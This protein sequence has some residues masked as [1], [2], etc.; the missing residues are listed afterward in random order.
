MKR[1][2]DE[3][4]LDDDVVLHDSRSD[5]EKQD[6]KPKVSKR[7]SSATPSRPQKDT[8]ATRMRNEQI[9]KQIAERE[10]RKKELETLRG[11][12]FNQQRKIF[13]RV[14][15]N[16][17]KQENKENFYATLSNT[18][19]RREKDA[20]I[21]AKPY[22]FETSLKKEAKEKVYEDLKKTLSE[23]GTAYLLSSLKL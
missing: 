10:E 3:V 13:N 11:K 14:V 22:L 7:P 15:P 5:W 12:Q 20:L 6:F 16:I 4:G 1:I 18:Q 23:N 8:F 17:D 9:K 2:A 21:D 19:K